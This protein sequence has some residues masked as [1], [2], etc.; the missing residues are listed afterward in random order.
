[1]LRAVMLFL[2][3]ASHSYGRRRYVVKLHEPLRLP[4]QKLWPFSKVSREPLP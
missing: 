4:I 1:M 3:L 2:E